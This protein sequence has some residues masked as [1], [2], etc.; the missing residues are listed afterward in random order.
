VIPPEDALK[1][2]ERRMMVLEANVA[3]GERIHDTVVEMG[4][5]RLFDI[6]GEYVRAMRRAELAWVRQTVDDIRSGRLEW[7]AEVIAMHQA[8][9]KEN[10]K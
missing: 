1:L 3:A 10:R 7:P 5:P 8:R 9:T 2:L 4:L 6:E